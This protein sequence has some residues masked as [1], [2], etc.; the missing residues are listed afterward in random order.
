VFK[1]QASTV[2]RKKEATALKMENLNESL[3]FARLQ[4]EEKEN[5]S[6]TPSGNK[7]SNSSYLAN[8]L[9]EEAKSHT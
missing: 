9:N 2:Q 3:R 4:L 6:I 5:N 8:F 1:Q 7:V